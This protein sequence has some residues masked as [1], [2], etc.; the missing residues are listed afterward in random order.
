MY[1]RGTLDLL[2]TIVA[3]SRGTG[4]SCFVTSKDD[5]G[6]AGSIRTN[7]NNLIDDGACDPH[8]SGDP[9]LGP[10]ADNGGPTMTHAL[11]P[12]SPA[13]D[14]VPKDGCTLAVDQRGL[15]RAF[16]VTS[17]DTPCDI[18]AFEWQP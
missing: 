4:G 1:V 13:I 12:G 8:L 18:G 10:L 6:E 9:M 2:N 16:A 5:K 11:L 3:Y 7:H 14:A 17:Y 15:L